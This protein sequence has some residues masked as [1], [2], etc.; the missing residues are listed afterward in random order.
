VIAVVAVVAY[1]GWQYFNTASATSNLT[2]S[3]TIEARTVTLASELSG[4]VLTVTLEEGQQV[5][6]G[7]ALVK[8]DDSALQA[9]YAQA[10]A[11]LQA[12]QANY[13]LL[14][15]GPTNEQIRQ[16]QAALIIATD[17]YSRTLAGSRQTDI[18]A[19][20]AAVNAAGEAYNKVK[21]G[22]QQGDYAAAEAAFRN[23]E[24]ALKQA[25]YAY[26]ATY[27][28]NPAGIDASPAALALE[29]AT[30]NYNAAKATY[31]K[32]AQSPDNAQI[33]AAYQ[34]VQ[35]ARAA[36]AKAKTPAL[37]YDIQQ[38]Q[39]QVEQ[40]QA[41]LDALKAG[42]RKQQLDAAKAQV[43]QAKAAAKAIEVQLAKVTISAPTD[44]VII[45][46]NVEPGEMAAA[47]AALFEIGRLDH[48]ELTVYLPEE[49]FALVKAGDTA[50]VNVD[51]YPGRTFTAT[52]LRIADQA[53]Y[54]P[55]NVQ[56]V[57][58]RKDTVFAIRLSL[59]N[60]DLALKPGMPADVTFEQK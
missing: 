27:K 52:V 14:S 16:A 49:K 50:R 24:A 44:G 35:S 42:T 36:L 51:A 21:A 12:A 28:R 25:Q 54:T 20:Q 7:Q 58:G 30:N 33:S 43:D 39:A 55:R 11:A 32:L 18:D 1:L 34:Q 19:A 29:Q 3:G 13:D 15:A 10:Q 48:L 2:A 60:T 59:D 41:A 26:D 31:D 53:E 38:S 46:R 45:N 47:G 57:E 6:T 17:S 8:L 5:R 4:R 22:P 37:D 56:T 40:A 9:Q 23:A